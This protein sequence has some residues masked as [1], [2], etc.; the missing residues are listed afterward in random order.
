MVG[1]RLLA[2]TVLLGA[3]SGDVAPPP[4]GKVTV[5]A[6]HQAPWGIAVDGTSVYWTN[7]NLG[8]VMKVPI[9]GGDVVT[10]A[11]GQQQPSEIV[12]DETSVY[13]INEAD[14]GSMNGAVM[15]VPL[16]GGTPAVVYQGSPLSLA[17][18][19]GTLYW[20]ALASA[21]SDTIMQLPAGSDQPETL[22]MGLSVPNAIA[23]RNGVVYFSNFGDMTIYKGPVQGRYG[24][25]LCSAGTSGVVEGFAVTDTDVYWTTGEYTT[26][27]KVSVD[28]G[29]PVSLTS[30]SRELDG[31]AVDRQ[32]VYVTSPG[33][34]TLFKLSLGG[35]QSATVAVGQNY[36]WR[37]V[38]DETS[39]YW[40]AD[41]G[42]SKVTP[43]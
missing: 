13:W 42:I 35:G 5:L 32:F 10:L 3:C 11:S 39:A 23:V 16:E 2:V 4:L 7:M 33:T 24:T 37:V 8:T 38:V 43:K 30:E 22:I 41:G 27:Q 20:G 25:S 18:D 26:L 15:K 19:G 1:V 17:I 40:I 6:E 29:T 14:I 36:P 31:I 21:G 12:V 28:G 34:E 9:D